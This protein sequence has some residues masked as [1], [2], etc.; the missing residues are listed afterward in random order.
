MVKAQA[1]GLSALLTM[2]WGQHLPSPPP[3]FSQMLEEKNILSAQLSN[4]SQSLREHQHH[5]SNLSNQCHPGGA[6]AEAA[7]GKAVRG[8]DGDGKRELQ[9]LWDDT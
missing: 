1:S 8:W 2:S 7:G 6:G 4:A 9:W 5:Y 3:Q